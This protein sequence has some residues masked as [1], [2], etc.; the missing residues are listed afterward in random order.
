MIRRLCVVLALV[1]C[2]DVPSLLAKTSGSKALFQAESGRERLE[3]PAQELLED[4]D[5]GVGE[6]R[7][8]P[9]STAMW[10]S[11]PS[12]TPE[13]SWRGSHRP[14]SRC[15]AQRAR[16]SA[17]APRGRVAHQSIRITLSGFHEAARQVSR[18]SEDAVVVTLAY[19]Q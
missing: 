9:F 1:V 13:P 17:A 7:T 5:E 16:G 10:S 18:M 14:A 6:P 4:K 11:S 12:T 8:A 19:L 3:I 2:A 15:T